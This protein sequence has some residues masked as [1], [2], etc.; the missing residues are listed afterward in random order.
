MAPAILVHGPVQPVVLTCHW[1]VRPVPVAVTQ[2]V[3]SAPS[4]TAVFAGWVLMAG[5]VLTV[6][7]AGSEFTPTGLH[8]M[9]ITQ[10]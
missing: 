8:D 10:R 4:Q 3:A 1:Y 7:I 6:K 9:A 5:D 2:N